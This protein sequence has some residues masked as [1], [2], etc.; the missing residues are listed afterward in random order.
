MRKILLGIF[1][2]VVLVTG[3]LVFL[4]CAEEPEVVEP[5][6]STERIKIIYVE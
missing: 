1:I 5:P 4:N 2:G 6:E 3:V